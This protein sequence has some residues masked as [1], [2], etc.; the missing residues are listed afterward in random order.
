MLF[1]SEEIYDDLAGVYTTANTFRKNYFIALLGNMEEVKASLSN[2]D[3]SDGYS[4]LQNED[5]LD[6]YTAKLNALNAQWQEFLNGAQSILTIKKIGVDAASG[7][8]TVADALDKVHLL[9]PLVA[10]GAVLLGTVL[11]NKAMSEAAARVNAY[12][13]ALIKN[14]TATIADATAISK[15]TIKQK[16]QVIQD[17]AAAA[18]SGKLTGAQA[19]Q[20][21]TEAGL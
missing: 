9:M 18:A 14:K 15:L 3:G 1:R 7:L 19:K 11:H 13:S 10:T 5:Y 16:Q 2:M 4:M 12:S 8:L 21:I 17:I 6:T 20:V